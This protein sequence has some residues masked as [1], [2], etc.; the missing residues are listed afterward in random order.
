[1]TYFSIITATNN[2]ESSILKALHSLKKQTFTSYEFI[3]IDNQ[4]ND[5]TIELIK[6]LNIS[7]TKLICERD[8]GVYNALN[9]GLKLA[10]GTYIHFLH[11]DDAYS[12][13]NVLQKVFLKSQKQS[14]DLISGNVNFCRKRDGKL[15]RK[16]KVIQPE[17]YISRND[18]KYGWMPPHTGTFFK[19]TFFE[20]VGYFDEQFKISGDYEWFLRAANFNPSFSNLS[21]DVVCMTLGGLSNS[22]N[23]L[24]RKFQEDLI[25]LKIHHHSRWAVLTKRL[26]KL[27]QFGQKYTNLLEVFKARTN[28]TKDEL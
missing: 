18:F 9:K 25:A 20:K 15:V 24:I 10:S 3:V 14:S 19:K 6:D 17:K 4:S 16:W 11:S 5:R 13:S 21:Y 28:P 22:N 2:S 8:T 1:M 12:D 23:F 26:G 27:S 7:H